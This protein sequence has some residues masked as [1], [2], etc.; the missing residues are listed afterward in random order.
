MSNPPVSIPELRL[1]IV[2]NV[3]ALHG[4]CIFDVILENTSDDSR[5]KWRAWIVQYVES[6]ARIV[7]DYEDP[8]VHSTMQDALWHLHLLIAREVAL[9]VVETGMRSG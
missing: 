8:R 7:T 4:D 5:P 3:R 2:A 1:L 9:R 6:L